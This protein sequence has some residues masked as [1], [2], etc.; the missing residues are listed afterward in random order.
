MTDI[1]VRQEKLD[2]D[3]QREHSHDWCKMG[4]EIG[5][6]QPQAEEASTHQNSVEWAQN[7]PHLWRVHS[8]ANT[9]ILVIWPPEL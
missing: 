2:R 3:S 9:F 5:V 1:P 6:M 4:A 7:S 8:S